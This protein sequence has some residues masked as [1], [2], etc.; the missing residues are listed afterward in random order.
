[1]IN[2]HL[3]GLVKGSY[4]RNGQKGS[5]RVATVPITVPPGAVEQWQV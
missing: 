4:D 5:G 3:P 2:F 1:V